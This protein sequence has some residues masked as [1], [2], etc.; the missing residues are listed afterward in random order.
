M[1]SR[2]LILSQYNEP[3]ARVGLKHSYLECLSALSASGAK[4]HQVVTA[5][6]LAGVLREELVRWAVEAGYSES[7]IR[8]LLSKILRGSG[9][10]H[11]RPGG[12]P[13]D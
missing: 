13:A 6:I 10:R 9:S 5:L 2:S 3:P 8:N 1:K 4:L 11:R 7:H 12:G